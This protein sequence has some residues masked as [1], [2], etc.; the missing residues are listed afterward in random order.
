M[1]N[2]TGSVQWKNERPASTRLCRPVRLQWLH[3]STEIA[4]KEEDF[5]NT[6]IRQ[7]QPLQFDSHCISYSLM[8]TMIDGKVCNALS[9]IS[10][11]RCYICNATVSEMNNLERIK[12]LPK[13]T[14]NFRF[15][16]STLH[17]H[18]R[19]FECLLHLSYRLQFKQW[20]K[21]AKDGTD[22]L[23]EEK[24]KKVQDAFRSRLGLIVDVPKPGSGT[25]NDGNTA[26][27]FFANATVSAEITGVDEELISRFGCILSALASGHDINL[28]TLLLLIITV[29]KQPSSS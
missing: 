6:Q 12:G 27:K 9:D 28:L 8:M 20:R 22:K 7:L 16:L 29:G 26:R 2:E 3:E 5:I 21:S 19:F 1:N 4:K 11:M 25:S 10:S 18:I 24:K 14:D 17:A 13:N 23:L 15:G